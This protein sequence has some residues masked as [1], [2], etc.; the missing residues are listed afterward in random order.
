MKTRIGAKQ[1]K[2][3]EEID[4]GTDAKNLLVRVTKKQNS[5]LIGVKKCRSVNPPVETGADSS[6]ILI[7]FKY[8]IINKK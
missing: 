1:T 2:T 8:I 3:V 5:T 6:R 4:P 7:I